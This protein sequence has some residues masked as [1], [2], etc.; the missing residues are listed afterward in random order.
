MSKYPDGFIPKIQYWKARHE[1]ATNS[2]DKAQ[3]ASKMAYFITRHTD[4]Y[5]PLDLTQID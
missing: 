1:A 5:G 3:A 4:T 2:Y